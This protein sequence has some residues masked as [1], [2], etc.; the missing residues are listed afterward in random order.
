ML[1][2]VEL[3]MYMK[4]Q[5]ILMTRC[6]DMDK[7]HQKCPKNGV[8]PPFVTPQD[9]FGFLIFGFLIFFRA[10]SLLYP[11]GALTACKKLE[12]TN[13]LSLRY[14]KTDRRKHT[15]TNRQGQLLRTPSGKPGVQNIKDIIHVLNQM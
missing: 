9:F 10:L 2:N 11:Y 3:I 1:D 8:F 12:K 7:K 4:F 14:S 15:R 6:R 5:K 13:K